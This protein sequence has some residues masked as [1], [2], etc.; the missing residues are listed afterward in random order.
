MVGSL[1]IQDREPRKSSGGLFTGDP[2]RLGPI[3]TAGTKTVVVEGQ[4]FAND[5]LRCLE[6]YAENRGGEFGGRLQGV[7]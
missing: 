1:T 5:R 6:L 3:R 4:L 2:V 7:Q